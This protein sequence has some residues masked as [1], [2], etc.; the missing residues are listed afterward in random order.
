MG[1]FDHVNFKMKCPKCGTELNNFQSKDGPCV[2][3]TLE[4]SDVWNLYDSCAKCGAWVEFT[5]KKHEDVTIEDFEMK[6][7]DK[8]SKITE[9]E[10]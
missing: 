2:L 9:E 7:E 4:I 8:I 3:A 10:K 6:V 5:R 1:M